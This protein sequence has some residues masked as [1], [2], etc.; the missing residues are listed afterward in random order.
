MQLCPK[1]FLNLYDNMKMPIE[2]PVRTFL[3]RDHLKLSRISRLFNSN[4]V[5]II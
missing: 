4:M 2:S 3:Y 5:Y 1:L